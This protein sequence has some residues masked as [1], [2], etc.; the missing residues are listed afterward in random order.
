MYFRKKVNDARPNSVK[1]SKCKKT[2]AENKIK[3]AS[4]FQ[5]CYYIKNIR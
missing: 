2:F 3:L 1:L 5:I 4:G